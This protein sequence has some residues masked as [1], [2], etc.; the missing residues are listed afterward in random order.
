MKVFLVTAVLLGASAWAQSPDFQASVSAAMAG[1]IEKQRQSVQKQSAAVT[2][3]APSSEAASFYTVPWPRAPVLPATIDC[4]PVGKDELHA[5]VDEAARNSGVKPQLIH[6][7]IRAESAARPCAVS[8]RGAQGLMQLMPATAQDLG[9]ADPFD[10]RENVNAGARL[11]KQLLGKYQG[12]LALTLGAYN[13]GP[14]RV[15][16]AGGVPPLAETIDYVSGIL[17]QLPPE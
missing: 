15:D 14:A 10:I 3:S 13:A 4:D 1:S 11:L 12:D 8:A 16:R 9:V 17:K 7:V 6:A 2:G 5:V